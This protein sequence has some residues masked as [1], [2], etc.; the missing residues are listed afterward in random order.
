[1]D[2]FFDCSQHRVLVEPVI[3][4]MHV[5]PRRQ[6]Q[7]AG[8]HHFLHIYACLGQALQVLFPILGIHNVGSLFAS[9]DAILVERAEHSVLLVDGVEESADM[10]SPSEVDPG[11]LD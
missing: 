1:L 3:A 4:H 11:E 2:Q 6:L 10:V 8:V 5:R 9:V 7:L